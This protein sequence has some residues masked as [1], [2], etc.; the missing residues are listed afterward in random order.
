MEKERGEAW[1]LFCIDIMKKYT[2]ILWLYECG[3]MDYFGL[4][5]KTQHH[6]SLFQNCDYWEL[7]CN[8][9]ELMVALPWFDELELSMSGSFLMSWVMWF[10]P[11]KYRWSWGWGGLCPPWQRIF[12]AVT[13]CSQVHKNHRYAMFWTAG[14]E[15]VIFATLEM[16]FDS[17]PFMNW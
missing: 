12:E 17:N 4:W 5:Q 10:V 11:R 2:L 6:R 8:D 1:F 16:V 3:Q 13:L 14:T 9:W 7:N 15:R